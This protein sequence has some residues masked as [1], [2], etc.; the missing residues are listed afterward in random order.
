MYRFGEADEAVFPVIR[1]AQC[2]GVQVFSFVRVYTVILY[3]ALHSMFVFHSFSS[4]EF[5]RT[6]FSKREGGGP[7]ANK[8]HITR[9]TTKRVPVKCANASFANIWYEHARQ[10]ELSI[11][12]M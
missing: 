10:R 7:R 3:I 6:R 11:Y 5:D 4:N 12:H 2:D 1:N 8:Q 9:R